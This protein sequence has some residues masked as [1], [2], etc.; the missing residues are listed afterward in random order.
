MKKWYKLEIRIDGY[1]EEDA[2]INA[3]SSS[4]DYDIYDEIE[5]NDSKLDY[6]YM[7]ECTTSLDS[8]IENGMD[9]FNFDDEDIAHITVYG[10]EDDKGKWHVTNDLEYVE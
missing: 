1:F 3:Y 6:E 4:Y 5:L 8:L 7:E 2:E 9:L 10:F